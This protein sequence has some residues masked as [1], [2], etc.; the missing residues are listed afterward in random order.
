MVSIIIPSTVYKRFKIQLLALSLVVS[1]NHAS[2]RFL[3]IYIGYLLTTVL[4]LRLCCFTHRTLHESHYLSSLFSPR[5]NSHSLRSSSFRPLLLPYF[6][7]KST[8]FSFIFICYTSSLELYLPN[9][10]RFAP[11]YM[12]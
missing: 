12:T 3:N 11:T 2:L 7:K 9:N 6:N 1:V 8:W 10:V 5:S 4:I